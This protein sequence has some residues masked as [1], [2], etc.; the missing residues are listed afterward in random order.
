M[1]Q[2]TADSSKVADKPD[3]FFENF[4]V[5]C[6]TE[7]PLKELLRINQIC[8]DKNIKFLCGDV[9]G[10]DKV[11]Y[12]PID[13]IPTGEPIAK[14]PKQE[15]MKVTKKHSATFVSLQDALDVD[16]T[17]KSNAKRL[18]KMDP[19]YFLMRVLL[20][21]RTKHGRNPSP[22][23][24]AED[25]AELL[26]LRDE[27]LDQFEVPKDKVPDDMFSNV[28][29]EVSPVCAIVGGV[30]AQEIIKTVSQR[31][32]P[33][34]NMFFFNPVEQIGLVDCIGN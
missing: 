26:K 29:A 13:R 18:D 25:S 3:S 12:K 23:K 2:V 5:V 22:K 24:R 8:R 11:I 10:M 20:N 4:S 16:W 27:V 30:M 7:C 15:A 34:N 14:V 19:S 21:F 17:K 1:V 9:F 31:E 32:A 28:Y 33:H 6:A